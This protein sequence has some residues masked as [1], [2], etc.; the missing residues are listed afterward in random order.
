MLK[1]FPLVT[2]K[3]AN[4]QAKAGK[5]TFIVSNNANKIMVKQ[6]LEK[7]YGVK[8]IDVNIINLPGKTRVAGRKE[9]TKRAPTKK[10]IVTLKKGQTLDVNKLKT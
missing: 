10:A 8:A 2:E 7:F 3:A 9:I 5:Y 4:I 1:F 6:A